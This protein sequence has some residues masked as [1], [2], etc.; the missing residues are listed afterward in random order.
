MRRIKAA[1]WILVLVLALSYC[2]HRVV[3][4]II[5]EICTQ[6]YTVK[7]SACTGN[8]ADAKRQLREALLYFKGRQHALELFLKRENVAALGVNLHGLDAYLCA[9]NLPDLCSEI[10]KAV[11]QARMLEHLFISIV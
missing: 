7:T 10:D 8:H 9:E 11:E 6:L 3:H 5:D 2:S 1:A 4:H